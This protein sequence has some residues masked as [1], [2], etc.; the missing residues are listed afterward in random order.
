MGHDGDHDGGGGHS[1]AVSVAEVE[2]AAPR[3]V[4]GAA[5][6]L[7]ARAPHALQRHALVPL[8]RPHSYVTWRSA[9][10]R[11]PS[12]SVRQHFGIPTTLPVPTRLS[13][14]EDMKEMNPHDSNKEDNVGDVVVRYRE[15]SDGEASKHKVAV[16]LGDRNAS[17][18]NI[19][20]NKFEDPK[21]QHYTLFSDNVLDA[22]VVVNFTIINSKEPVNQVFHIVTDKLN[23]VGMRMWFLANPPGDAAIQVQHIEAFTWLNSSYSSVLK[24]PESHFMINYYFKT[25]QDKPDK[26]LKFRNPKYLSILNHLKFYLPKIFPKLNKVLFLDDDIVVQRDLSSLWSIDLKGK[27]NGAVQTCGETFHRFDRYLN[28][29]NPLI[30]KKFDRRACG[31]VYGMNIFDLSEWRKQ[32]ITDVYHYWQNMNADRQLWKLGTLPAGLVT[33]WNHTFP[34]D[35]SWHLLGLGYKPN[36]NQRDIERAAVIH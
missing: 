14:R 8:L 36:V 33:F 29:S 30:A 6:R 2:V 18:E 26:N 10:S 12:N 16:V 34:I 13:N 32:N 5:D 31:W 3:H 25:G 4:A 28:F 21:L 7:T 20:K 19:M 17:S 23:Y 9:I 15:S 35:G 24:Q 22:S 1:S 27:V 11:D